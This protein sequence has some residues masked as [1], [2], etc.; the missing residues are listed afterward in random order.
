[1]TENGGRPLGSRYHI[2]ELIGRGGMGEVWRGTDETGAAVA[3]KTLQ[4]QFAED[5][6]VVQRFVAERHLLTS[7]RDPHVVRV[8]DLVAEG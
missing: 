7:A 5:P 3:V 1:M 6:G 8:R 2:G 4:P